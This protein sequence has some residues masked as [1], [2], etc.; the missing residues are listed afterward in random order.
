MELTGKIKYQNIATGAWS[1]IAD[2]G[3]TYELYKP[4]TE[5]TQDGIKVKITG[6]IREDIM[7]VAMIGP[8]LEVKSYTIL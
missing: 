7:T 3:V 2:N 8:I 6:E 1:L 5:I 4:H